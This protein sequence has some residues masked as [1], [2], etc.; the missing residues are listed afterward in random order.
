MSRYD[1]RI[2]DNTSMSFEIANSVREIKDTYGDNASVISKKKSLHKFGRTTNADAGVK[3]TVAVF[4]DAV[5]NETFATSNSV[6]RIVSSSA[7]DTETI[8]VEG[9]YFDS[10][11]NFVFSSQEVTLTGQTAA[12]L[13]QPL[14]RAT[15]AYVKKGTFASPAT[16]LRGNVVVYD[17]AL[18]TS[19]LTSGKPN[20]DES[21]K[22]I[23]QGNT[24][25]LTAKNQSEKCATALSYLDYWIITEVYAGMTR[26][27]G[28]TAEVD[29]DIEVREIGGVWRPLGLEINLRRG[30]LDAQ[31]DEMN[32]PF[33]VPK[34]SDVRM[35]ATSDA[36]DITI[37]GYIHG[38]LALVVD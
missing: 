37:A 38:Y 19:G 13:S 28:A 21:V 6:D 3:T 30:S 26:D 12:S 8:V 23:V 9:H 20:V 32:P 4:Q 14:C 36:A 31:H 18:A 25:E 35:V 5:V 27:A 11:N 1:L 2:A 15:R 17:N 7:T 22:L 29:I 24:T 34:N 10:S 16:F 33:I